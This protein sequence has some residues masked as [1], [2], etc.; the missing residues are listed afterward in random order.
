VLALTALAYLTG[1]VFEGLP[2][3][4][5]LAA[6][7]ALLA[8]LSQRAS[9]AFAAL[10][11]VHTLVILAPPLALVDG[12]DQPLEAAAALAAVIVALATTRRGRL[13]APVALL[14]LASVEVVTAGGAEHTGQTLLSVLWALTGV[15]ALV[16]GL[17]ED[18]KEIRLAALSLLALTAAKVFLY[19]LSELDSLARV[20]SFIVFGLLLLLGAFAWQRVRPRALPSTE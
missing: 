16:F 11:A 8:F 6:E 18:R 2:L 5:A 20:A 14:Y 7:A 1:L 4:V 10:A 12:L 17:V 3:T 13:L 15:G 19:D 9:L